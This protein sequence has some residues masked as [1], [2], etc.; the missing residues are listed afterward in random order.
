M[1]LNFINYFIYK[2]VVNIYNLVLYIKYF[3]KPILYNKIYSFIL[4][5]E[6]QFRHAFFNRH[7]KFMY[8][9]LF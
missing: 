2:L 7:F 1:Q 5:F 8:K 6:I 9:I 3:F 4:N